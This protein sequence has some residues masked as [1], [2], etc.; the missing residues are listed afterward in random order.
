MGQEITYPAA[1]KITRSAGPGGGDLS[2]KPLFLRSR[3]CSLFNLRSLLKERSRD[4][5]NAVLKDELDQIL[6]QSRLDPCLVQ[7]D[8]RYLLRISEPL[9][10]QFDQDKILDIQTHKVIRR[11]KN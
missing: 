1:L 6:F 7:N 3:A 9:V 2:G 10:D 4:R 8:L 11:L 5:S